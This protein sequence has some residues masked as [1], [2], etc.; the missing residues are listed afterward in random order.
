MSLSEDFIKCISYE[1]RKQ[2]KN[3]VFNL[4]E[5]VFKKYQ[6]KSSEHL[7]K[8]IKLNKKT[9][10]K[11]M[12]KKIN[13]SFNYS[14]YLFDNKLSVLLG[15]KTKRDVNNNDDLP[16]IFN[17]KPISIENK[18]M[19]KTISQDKEIVIMSLN[20][21][22]K[23]EVQ[24]ETN[25]NIIYYDSNII[26]INKSLFIKEESKLFNFNEVNDND[27]MYQKEERESNSNRSQLET[28]ST[29]PK[30][31]QLILKG[32]LSDEVVTFTK[33]LN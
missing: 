1:I 6:L 24:K 26:T 7:M 5:F 25:S 14:I 19:S 22:A 28:K 29:S 2:I 18:Q 20:K 9:A 21:K 11:Q 27:L 10:K 8:N 32:I 15:N 31:K 13:N 30:A 17:M 23:I 4:F 12:N 16:P 33:C 3:Y